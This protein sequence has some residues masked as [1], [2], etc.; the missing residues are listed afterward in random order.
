MKSHGSPLPLLS[1]SLT[2]WQATSQSR[3]K[4]YTLGE[5]FRYGLVW[6]MDFQFWSSFLHLN[7]LFSFVI[8]KREDEGDWTKVTFLVV[9]LPI[10]VIFLKPPEK[11]NILLEAY[12]QLWLGWVCSCKW[13]SGIRYWRIKGNFSLQYLSYLKRVFLSY[14]QSSPCLSADTT[15]LEL[16]WSLLWLPS[17]SS[18]SRAT[19]P[20]QVLSTGS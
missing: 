13:S 16:R 5:T 4:V 9:N 6:Y 18:A 11:A 7:I 8:H 3:G 1:L 14:F 10:I 19:D 2:N 12:T 20:S 15:R 17:M